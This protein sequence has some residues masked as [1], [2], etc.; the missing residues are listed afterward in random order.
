M[1]DA[2]AQVSQRLRRKLTLAIWLGRAARQGS[3]VLAICACAALLGRVSF[4]LEL[5]QAALCFLPLVAVPFSAWRGTPSLVPSEEGLN[6]WI[7]L[8]SGAHGYLLADF[9]LDD[10][11]WRERAAQ[12]L[13]ALP[14]LPA[15]RL[16]QLA[17]PVLPAL[18]FAALALFIPLASADS[19]PS[20][21]LFERAIAGLS[22]QLET[23]NEIVDLDEIAADELAERI[24]QLGEDLDAAEPEA[25]LEAIDALR[26]KLAAHGQD[27]ASLAQELGDRF[28]AIGAS[29]MEDTEALQA[30]LQDAL[31]RMLESGLQDELMQQLRELSPELARSM[32][33]NEMRLPE[34]FELSAEQMRTL[35]EGL[36]AGLQEKLSTLNLAGLVNMEQ[37]ALARDFASLS[38]L[39]AELH[40]C[41]EDCKKPGGT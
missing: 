20:T 29:A 18:A 38:E 2:L 33:G 4:D 19:G 6:A 22:E 25:M 7:D 14:E 41:D 28:G 27:A 40:E 10:P 15:L 24:E 31:A 39:A 21:G 13:E 5:W 36:R 16:S 35:S 30:L 3:L 37:L 17:R 26:E 23:L 8:H 12:Q 32:A 34:G 11:R 1:S 9:E